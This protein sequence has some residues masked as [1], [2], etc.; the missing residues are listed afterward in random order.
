[1]IFDDAELHIYGYSLELMLPTSSGTSGGIKGIWDGGENFTIAFRN[2]G[3]FD[4]LTQVILHEI[5]EPCS[6]LIF[7]SLIFIT[8][9]RRTK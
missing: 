8:R 3:D 6:G 2:A 5:P 1:M 4:P 7:T 9:L